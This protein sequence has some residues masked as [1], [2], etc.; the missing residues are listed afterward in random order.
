VLA[1][2]AQRRSVMQTEL[3]AL[4]VVAAR[5]VLGRIPSEALPQIA[6]DLLEAGR[7]TRSLRRLAGEMQPTLGETGPLFEE[8]LDELGIAVPDRSRAGL[9][10]AKAYAVQIIEGSL[11]AYDGARH[12]WGIQLEVEGLTLELGP[13]VYWASEWDEADTPHRRTECETGIRAA[14]FELVG[15]L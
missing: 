6:A 2:A 1:P 15:A 5:W 3:G 13:F 7:D 14:A 8:V 11:S 4:D 9:V 12:I 10:L